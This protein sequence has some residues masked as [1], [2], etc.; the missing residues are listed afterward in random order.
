VPSFNFA[1]IFKVGQSSFTCGGAPCG[2]WTDN[3]TPT[4]PVSTVALS[5]VAGF[6]KLAFSIPGTSATYYLLTSPSA[7]TEALQL[8]TTSGGAL[9]ASSG[10]RVAIVRVQ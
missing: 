2:F 5:S 6:N 8:L 10:L 3:G 7:G 4:Y 1:D 9:A